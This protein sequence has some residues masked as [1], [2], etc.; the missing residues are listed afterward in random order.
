MAGTVNLA[1]AW[2]SKADDPV[3]LIHEAAGHA[4]TRRSEPRIRV[5]SI[6]IAS[7]ADRE[8]FRGRPGQYVPEFGGFCAYGTAKGYK[9]SID[10]KEFGASSMENS[11]LNYDKKIWATFRTRTRCGVHPQGRSQLAHGPEHDPKNPN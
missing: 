4:A 2:R 8:L 5:P 7:T 10:Y 11:D 6:R 9:V 1:A 3:G